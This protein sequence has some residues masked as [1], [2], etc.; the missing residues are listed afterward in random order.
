MAIA[1]NEGIIDVMHLV[2]ESRLPEK[3]CDID[4]R[5][6][7]AISLADTYDGLGVPW[8]GVEYSA[9]LYG[10]TVV[11]Q[12]A[13]WRQGAAGKHPQSFGGNSELYRR[14]FDVSRTYLKIL[15]ISKAKYHGEK[16]PE[17]DDWWDIVFLPKEK[18]T[19]RLLTKHPQYRHLVEIFGI[20]LDKVDKIRYR[21]SCSKS[22][23]TNTG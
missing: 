4:L 14:M 16:P 1:I 13:T 6:F 15:T 19:R 22:L 2:R 7:R 10:N 3:P 11:Y 5:F 9:I 12:S 21:V 18:E 23:K 20:T 17:G 8:E